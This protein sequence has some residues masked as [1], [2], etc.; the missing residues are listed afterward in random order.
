MAFWSPVSHLV[1]FGAMG[2]PCRAVCSASWVLLCAV[3][4]VFGGCSWYVAIAIVAGVDCSMPILADCVHRFG[5][6]GDLFLGM[7]NGKVVHGNVS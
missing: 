4:A 7:L 5:I 1:P 3:G 2:I 6:V